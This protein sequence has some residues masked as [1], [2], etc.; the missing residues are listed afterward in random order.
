L[1]NDDETIFEFLRFP[2]VRLDHCPPDYGHDNDVPHY[3]SALYWSCANG[4]IRIAEKLLDS[5]ADP[6]RGFVRGDIPFKTP[7]MAAFD[8]GASELGR[9]LIRQGADADIRIAIAGLSDKFW[10]QGRSVREE[11]LCRPASSWDFLKDR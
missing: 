3:S 2:K 4:N 9:L 7:L 11:H 8:R 6:N 1:R 5:G 10:R